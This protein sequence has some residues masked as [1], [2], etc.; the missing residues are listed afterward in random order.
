MLIKVS[1]Y[2]N[3]VNYVMKIDDDIYVDTHLLHLYLST[4]SLPDNTFLCAQIWTNSS[5]T[6]DPGHKWHVTYQVHKGRCSTCN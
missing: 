1:Q 3:T 4:H 5:V 2:C 6:R